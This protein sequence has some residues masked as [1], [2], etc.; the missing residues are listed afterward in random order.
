M[1]LDDYRR[2]WFVVTHR[3]STEPVD[4]NA[5]YRSYFAAIGRPI[6]AFNGT[7]E[8]GAYLYEIGNAKTPVVPRPTWLPHGCLSASLLKPVNRREFSTTRRL[9][10]ERARHARYSDGD[11]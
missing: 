9:V 6:A 2:V 10:T 5:T 3:S 1:G 4:R 7:N 11:A 8:A